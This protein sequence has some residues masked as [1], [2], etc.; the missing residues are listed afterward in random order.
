MWNNSMSLTLVY[1][2]HRDGFWGKTNSE[3]RQL[4]GLLSL[5]SYINAFETHNLK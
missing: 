1:V 5:V 3:K 4:I 2:K